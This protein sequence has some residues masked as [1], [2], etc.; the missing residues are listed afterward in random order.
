MEIPGAETVYLERTIAA[1]IAVLRT[2]PRAPE[3]PMLWAAFPELS[4][5]FSQEA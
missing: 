3:W 5:Y 2:Q 1:A 4:G